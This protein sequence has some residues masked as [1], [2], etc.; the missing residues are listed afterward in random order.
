MD[1]IASSYLA[2]SILSWALPIGLLVIVGIWW[3]VIL[4]R[5]GSD[6]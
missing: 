6:T 1:L 2:G 5:R 4:R 3:M